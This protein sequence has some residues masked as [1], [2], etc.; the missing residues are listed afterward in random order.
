MKSK[1]HAVLLVV[2]VL[3][4]SAFVLTACKF[5][6]T[7]QSEETS[8]QTEISESGAESS[9]SMGGADSTDSQSSS[10]EG[11]GE[12]S[13]PEIYV[14]SF[15][16]TE[17]AVTY[18]QAI[19][20][21]PAMAEQ[22]G[23]TAQGWFI[24]EEQ[25]TAETVWEYTENKTAEAR[26]TANS[27][28]LTFG[29]TEYDVTYGQA[30]GEL[31]AIP[32]KTGYTPTWFIGE[33]QLTAE[34]VWE[35]AED[36]T[37][38]IVDVPKNDTAYTV[39]FYTN[40]LDN[41]EAYAEQESFRL[42]LTGTTDAQAQ[43]TGDVNTFFHGYAIN[44]EKSTLSGAIAADGSL[45]L[46]V[47]CAVNLAEVT[48]YAEFAEAVAG[49]KYVVLKNDITYNKELAAKFA[50]F[51]GVIDGKGYALNAVNLGSGYSN[52]AWGL[53]D[54]FEGIIKD[55]CLD[56]RYWGGF[57]QDTYHAGSIACSFGGT[58][59][60]VLLKSTMLDYYLNNQWTKPVGVMFGQL[61]AKAEVTNCI[62]QCAATN[63]Y[64]CPAS[65]VSNP[66]SWIAATAAEGATV[67]NVYVINTCNK[68][69]P[70]VRSGMEQS[71]TC[72]VS[73]EDTVASA[74]AD[75]PQDIWYTDGY[76][77]PVL[78][79]ASNA[80]TY[81]ALR[82]KTW[83]EVSTF[84][85][86]VTAV[87]NNDAANI[88]L[89]SDIA[90]DDSLVTAVGGVK[91]V[92]VNFS[93]EIDG[94][95]H[96]L[97]GVVLNAGNGSDMRLFRFFTG[98][99]KNI[100]IE[101]SM[102]SGSGQGSAAG[103]IALE[104]SGIADNIKLTLRAH[105]L[106]MKNGYD[107]QQSG[108]LFGRLANGAFVKNVFIDFTPAA[109]D[110]N[111]SGFGFVAGF[112]KENASV[113]VKNVVVVNRGSTVRPIIAL[114]YNT[115]TINGVKPSATTRYHSSEANANTMNGTIIT[116]ALV[117]SEAD[118]IANAG[119]ILGSA[120]ICDGEKLPYLKANA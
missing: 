33:V 83:V 112:V 110:S 109:G 77:A 22:T 20:E 28:K 14:L 42:D 29:E 27:Y 57:G 95:G 90:Y 100:A 35:Y 13:T 30:I 2:T 61:T 115:S 26:Y 8:A 60:N 54:S 111:V 101:A 47:Y 88:K 43:Y 92:S 18:G 113:T 120:W 85:D 117:G 86:F 107:T 16:E 116:N 36:K 46:E 99:I 114:A 69:L 106:Y 23:Y 24:G 73:D 53:F 79:N 6:A 55:I 70:W 34:T 82:N 66:I 68:T 17:Y 62:I 50:S 118:V 12:Q 52:S 38:Q 44:T 21:L 71:E 89:T 9:S 5:D 31:P 7:K 96:T 80:A 97:T 76:H 51:K 19:G 1:L 74:C 67:E 15:G 56:I 10:Q 3:L 39:K 91:V 102:Q 64:K 49:N 4:I 59:Q 37:A 105:Q 87:R 40:N 108:G 84:A 94:Q 98:N 103:V 32:E 72:L 78:I 81:E 65:Q 104:F 11:Q 63:G 75:L 25:L 45:V 48:T 58:A 119:T 41:Q 93:G